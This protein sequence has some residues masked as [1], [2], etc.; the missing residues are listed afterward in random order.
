[1]SHDENPEGRSPTPFPYDDVFC[2]PTSLVALPPELDA[3]NRVLRYYRQHAAR[4]IRVSF[5]EDSGAASRC[6]S[7][8]L[9]LPCL[10]P[11]ETSRPPCRAA[12]RLR[13]PGMKRR[14]QRRCATLPWP[15]QSQP[16]R[17]GR[18]RSAPHP[19][20]TSPTCRCSSARSS[21]RSTS[22]FEGGWVDGCVA[23]VVHAC[24]DRCYACVGLAE[25]CLLGCKCV[26]V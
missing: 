12:A 18:R 15:P 13:T 7:L 22:A 25:V 26:F 2:F 14:R 9:R 10:H 19:A 1:M 24:G 17:D 11:R 21:R 6:L 5:A 23:V 4:F 3:T 8:L 20:P 16:R